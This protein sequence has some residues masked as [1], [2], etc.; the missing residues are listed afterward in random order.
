MKNPP[1]P[2][3]P[4]RDDSMFANNEPSDNTL[5]GEVIYTQILEGEVGG[6]EIIEGEVRSSPTIEGQVVKKKPPQQSN[7]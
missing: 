5:E 4:I 1:K 7:S 2:I 6:G 3:G